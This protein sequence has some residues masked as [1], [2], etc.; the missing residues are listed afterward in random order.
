M[1]PLISIA[2]PTHN[3]ARYAISAIESILSISDERLELVV[4]DTS[5]DGELQR[6][7]ETKDK[8]WSIDPRLVYCRPAERL[9]M[10][11]NHNYAI[12]HT[13]GEFVCLIGD[14]D[15]ITEDVLSAAQWALPHDID[16]IAPNVV[17]NYVWP[18][19]RSR[20]M[21]GKHAARLYFARKMGD[22]ALKD[23][24]ESVAAAL[25]NA[26]Q[27]TDGLPKI[28]HGIVRRT[29]LEKVH[30]LS[31]AFF[32]GSSP[33][34][35]GALGLSLCSSKFLVVDFPLTIPGASGG[36]NTGRS[37]MNT[38]KGALNKE[39]Q[40]KQFEDAGWSAGV[41]KFFAVET[42]WAHAALETLSRIAPDKLPQFNFARL[43]GVCTILHSEFKAEIDT[44]A[45]QACAITR[46]T[47]EELTKQI[48]KEA[49]LFKRERFWKLMKR[50]TKPTA[51]G[52]RSY[53]S[54]LRTVAD[55][56]AAL[57]QHMK[58]KGLS[59]QQIEA[60]MA[61]SDRAP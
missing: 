43:L 39:L 45:C 11:G 27:G 49:G 13:S 56:P 22:W 25:K 54:D 24:A 48:N 15:T 47:S 4:S 26:G 33:D 1:R 44:A 9:D 50:L 31:G 5:T 61:H 37:A 19:F 17:A 28:Y 36:S 23:C 14:D 29:V 7:I 21:G 12:A 6:H 18:D 55:S 57:K 53:I 38:H 41:P 20:L 52:G 35:S 42:V 40:T 8:P 10:T 34:V 46:Q 51:A 30:A 59:W 3:R 32:H 58:D 2:V 16:I 60:Q